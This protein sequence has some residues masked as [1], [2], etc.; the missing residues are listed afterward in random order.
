M[1]VHGKYKKMATVMI[2]MIS[3]KYENAS[4]LPI[5]SNNNIFK[6]FLISLI[7]RSLFDEMAKF[8]VVIEK[9]IIIESRNV[10]HIY[11]KF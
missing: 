9:Q 5:F 8:F 1:V 10:L 11:K 6:L 7:L 2:M 4:A 3:S